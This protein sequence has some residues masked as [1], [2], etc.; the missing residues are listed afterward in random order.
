M[1]IVADKKN[2][3]PTGRWRVELQRGTERY[4]QRHDTYKAAERDEKRVRQLWAAGEQV[5]QPTAK[6]V[7]DV[8]TLL[9]A[10][11]V[12]MGT[13][14][15][16][17][18]QE[19]TC[20]RHIDIIAGII[21]KKVALDDIDTIAVDKVVKALKA[22]SAANGTI[23]RYLSHFKTFLTWCRSRK[24]TKLSLE[25]VQFDWAKESPGRIRW[26]TAA[27]EVALEKHLPPNV[28][29]LVKVAIE[30]GCRRSELLGAEVEQ[31]NGNRLH[32]W[33][34]KTD[35]PRTVYMEPE[36]TEMLVGLLT[37]EDPKDRM[38]TQNYL[39]R[40]WE[41]ARSAMKLDGDED[42]VFHACRHTRA[43]RLLEAGV[44]LPTIQAMLGHK[45]IE[46]TMRY[47][48]VK[49]SNIENAME[50]VGEYNRRISEKARTSA[51]SSVPHLAA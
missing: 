44:D 4:R 48:H 11:E 20:W 42:F 38:P 5:A 21:G 1:S 14:W 33:E 35:N 50:K 12:A 27:E 36:I 16:G 25:D 43:T 18:Q 24:L 30:T 17:Q 9:S 28:W 10:K 46:T 39:R 49:A 6:K 31:V 19:D 32:L 2:G 26:I 51:D 40:Q 8:H 29:R 45:Q 41:K 47:A 23:N 13:L 7:P 15:D 34:T 22:R 3:R 37:A